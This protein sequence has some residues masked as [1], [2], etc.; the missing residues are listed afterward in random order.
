[1]NIEREYRKGLTELKL[2]V[3]AEVLVIKY[4]IHRKEAAEKSDVVQIGSLDIDLQM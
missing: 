1:V 3:E 4:E 2:H